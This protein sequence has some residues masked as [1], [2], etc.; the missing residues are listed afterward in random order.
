MRRRTIW[1]TRKG[2][3]CI[4]GRLGGRNGNLG[5]CRKACRGLTEIFHSLACAFRNISP[6]QN[7]PSRGFWA[8]MGVSPHTPMGLE[9]GARE[10]E[11]LLEKASPALQLIAL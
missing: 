4:R 2:L 7:L 9:A 6:A 1:V 10:E 3:G 11:S 8:S 5:L